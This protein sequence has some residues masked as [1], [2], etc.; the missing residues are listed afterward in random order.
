[1]KS[2]KSPGVNPIPAELIQA[3]GE[4]L[5]AEI[6]K[7]IRLNWNIEELPH[8]CKESV[9]VPVHKKGDKTVC[10]SYQGTSFLSNSYKISSTILLSNLTPSAE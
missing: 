3:G 9:V 10:R 1:L 5:R 2:C 6:H 4:V 7:R 8:Q